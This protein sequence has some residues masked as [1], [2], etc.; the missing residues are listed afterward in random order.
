MR[1]WSE[2]FEIRILVLVL[3]Q[4][5]S[6]DFNQII[7]IMSLKGNSAT[8]WPVTWY[9]LSNYVLPLVGAL[10]HQVL[11]ICS[12]ALHLFSG[13]KLLLT[14]RPNRTI[15]KNWR[16][17]SSRNHHWTR[18]RPSLEIIKILASMMFRWLG[19]QQKYFLILVW[20]I[21]FRVNLKL[22]FNL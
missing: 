10:T 22:L 4:K 7:A 6:A 3:L 19:R 1:I 14:H 2:K 11:I 12:A 18:P 16:L 5:F 17:Q 20:N 15:E 8:K 9:L 21:Q 13:L